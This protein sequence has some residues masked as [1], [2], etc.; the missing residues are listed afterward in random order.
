M[1][2]FILIISAL[3]FFYLV[4][5]FFSRINLVID[6]TIPAGSIADY[7]VSMAPLAFVRICPVAV[8]LAVIYTFSGLSKNNELIAAVSCGKHPYSIFSVFIIM[9]FIISVLSIAVNEENV[10]EAAKRAHDIRYNRMGGDARKVWTNRII[11]G[12]GKRRFFIK[13]IDVSTGAFENFE[14]TKFSGSGEEILKFQAARGRF[15]EG[16]WQFHDIILRRYSEEGRMKSTIHAESASADNS[17]WVISAGTIILPSGNIR[18]IKNYNPGMEGL[19]ETIKEFTEYKLKYDEMD[20]A[21]LREYADKL[22]DAGFNPRKE[23]TALHS[24]IAIPFSSLILMIIGISL[25]IRNKK[26]GIMIGLGT[27]LVLS[28]AYYLLMSIG[29]ILGEFL[30]PPAA[31][32]WSA[33]VLF[34]VPGFYFLLRSKYLES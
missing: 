15:E 29:N 32:A 26:G 34:F 1:Y 17:K 9:G 33:N 3:V 7:Y 2:S 8:L 5:D 24:K 20:Y 6:G 10:P 31:G 25:S 14:I 18:E 4:F 16:L 13:H 22:K 19:S 30:I 11:Y 21:G 12:S 28:L 27:A 23:I